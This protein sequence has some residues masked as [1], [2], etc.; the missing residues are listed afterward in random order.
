MSRG[1]RLFKPAAIYFG[2]VFGVGF[3]LGT[4]RTLWLVPRT[5]LRTAELIE[6]PFMLLAIVFAG[7]WVERRFRRG[8]GR[9]ALLGVG[10]I[11]AVLVLAADVALGV[12][13]RGLSPVEVFTDRDEVAG[14]V[15]YL[16]IALFALMPWLFARRRGRERSA[17]A[18]A[19]R[20]VVS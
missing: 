9:R 15:Y 17:R 4:V 6:S 12:G 7:R 16:L 18:G 11:A 14:P 19:E 2:L 20:V 3:V 1:R 8:L 10:L 13:L 5:D